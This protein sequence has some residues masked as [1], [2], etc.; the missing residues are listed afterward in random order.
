[1][2]GSVEDEHDIGNPRNRKRHERRIDDR[3]QK[4]AQQPERSDEMK[5]AAAHAAGRKQRG[6]E[7]GEEKRCRGH[8][9][10]DAVAGIEVAV[11][12]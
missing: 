8:V 1:M 6:R 11:R 7:G 4:D 9:G 12:A 5:Q 10:L 2:L 3:D